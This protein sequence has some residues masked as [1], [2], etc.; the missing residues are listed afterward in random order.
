MLVDGTVVL[1]LDRVVLAEIVPPVPV[2]PAVVE[3]GNPYGAEVVVGLEVLGKPVGPTVPVPKGPEEEAPV[4]PTEPA[5]EPV[6]DG[7]GEAMVPV[8]VTEG[9]KLKWY[10]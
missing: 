3:L 5:E 9:P 1:E 8:A 10:G 7:A 6:P 2:G 4:D